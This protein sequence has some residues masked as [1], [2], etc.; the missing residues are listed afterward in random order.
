M[1]GNGVMD[2]AVC[3]QQVTQHR[4]ATSAFMLQWA[5]RSEQPEMV[6]PIDAAPATAT[7]SWSTHTLAALACWLDDPQP[8]AATPYVAHV[9]GQSAAMRSVMPTRDGGCQMIPY[10]AK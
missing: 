8:R 2:R 3:N 6:R 1:G 4:A 5:A 9:A 10:G 7:S